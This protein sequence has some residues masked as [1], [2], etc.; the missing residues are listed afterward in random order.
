MAVKTYRLIGDQGI[1]PADKIIRPGE[2]VELNPESKST[3]IWLEDGVIAEETELTK[4]EAERLAAEAE[5]AKE[6]AEEAAKRALEAG[7]K[8]EKKK[9]GPKPKNEKEGE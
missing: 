3:Q 7:A 5:R 8:T 4:A 9:P 6:T 1:M 2:T